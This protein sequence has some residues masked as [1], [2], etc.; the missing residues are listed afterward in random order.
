MCCPQ[1]KWAASWHE[2]VE[3]DGSPSIVAA[4]RRQDCQACLA[5]PLCTQAQQQGR[6]LRL[7]PQDQYEAL[8]AARAW[9]ASEEG[10]ERYKRRA[11]VEGTLSQGVRAFGLRRSRYWGLA[12]THLQHIATA[13]ANSACVP[14]AS[15]R[16]ALIQDT[17]DSATPRLTGADLDPIVQALGCSGGEVAIVVANGHVMRFPARAQFGEEELAK[18]SLAIVAINGANRLNIAFRTVPG[19]YRVKARSA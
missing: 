17:A 1:G 10:I 19:S 2:R 6:Q 13:A 9:Y 16:V 11:G 8:T 4:C 14:G 3:Q 12:K 5:R 15:A 18:L 7:P